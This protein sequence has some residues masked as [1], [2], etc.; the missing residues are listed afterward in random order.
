MQAAQRRAG[1][2][3]PAPLEAAKPSEAGAR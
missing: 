2:A 3:V 1:M